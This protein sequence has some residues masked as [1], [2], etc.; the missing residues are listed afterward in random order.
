M[1]VNLMFPKESEAGLGI[2]LQI[3]IHLALQK[4]EQVPQKFSHQ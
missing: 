1:K 4:V 2:E 3:L